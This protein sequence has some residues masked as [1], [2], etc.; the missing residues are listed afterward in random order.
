MFSRTPFILFALI[1]SLTTLTKGDEVVGLTSGDFRVDESGAATYNI[2]INTPAGRAGVTPQISLSYSS[3]SLAEGPVGVGWGVSGLSSISRCPQVPIHDDNI[4]E[5]QFDSEDKY[6]LDGQRLI[7]KSGTYG[8]NGSTYRTEVDN[9]SLITAKGSATSNGPMYFEISNKAGETHYYGDSSSVS[10][11]FSNHSD[12]FVE[13]GGYT[14]GSLARSW[15]LKV[16]KDV[17]D[18]Y[19]LFNYD[20]DT[21]E[22]IFY[23]DNIQY[24]GNLNTGAAPYAKM[25]FVYQDYDKGFKGYMAGAHINHNQI[26]ERIDTTIDGGSYRSYFLEY[27][28]SSFIE[29]RTLLT[30]VQECNNDVSKTTCFPETQFD[31]QR[32]A[33]SSSGKV[34]RCE[35]EPGYEHLCFWEPSTTNYQPFPTIDTSLA[36]DTDNRQTSQVFDINGDG[37]HD[38][39]YVKSGYWRAKLGPNFSTAYTLSSRGQ[40][41]KEYALSID[42]NGDGVRDL[43]VADSKSSYWYAISYQPDEITQEICPPGEPCEEITITTSVSVKNLGV[44]ATGLEGEAQVMDVNGDGLEDIVFRT[45][46]YIKAH[47]NNGNGGFTAN[48]L[49]YSFPTT[50]TSIEM[51][52]EMVSQ[53]ADMKSA[54]GIDINGDGRSDLILKVTTTTGGCYYR[55]RLFPYITHRSECIYDIRGTWSSSTSSNYKLFQSSG[56]TDSPT[57]TEVQNLGSASG[58]DTLRIAD[59]NGD[60]LSDLLYV[61]SDR[62]YYRLSDGTQLLSAHDA[63]LA[64]SSTK[65][66]LDQFVDLNGDGRTDVLHATNTSNWSVNFSR[67]TTDAEWV[68]FQPRGIRS[69]NTNATV[70]FG[71]TNGDGKLNMLTATSS[72]WKEYSNRAGTKENVI[73]TIT[74]GNGVETNITY[75][76]MTDTSVYVIQASDDDINSDTFSPVSGMQLVSRVTTDINNNNEVAVSYQYGG[77]LIHKNG[78]GSL[79]FEML[80]TTDEQSGVITETHYNQDHEDTGN[81]FAMARMPEYT[82]QRL[83]GALLSSASSSLSTR[84]TNQGSVLPYISQ[85]AEKSYVYGSDY[86]STEVSTTVSINAYDGWG[87]LTTSN[88]T[89]TDTVTGDNIETITTNN[90][91]NSTEQRLG[92]LKSTTVK[93]K[94]TGDT[95]YTTRDTVFTYNSDNLLATSVVS[96][97]TAAT[98]LTT[99][100]SY[101]T[102]GNKTS[103][104]VTGYSTATGTNQTRTT[105]NN[106]QNGGRFLNYKQNTLG[107]RVTYKYNGVSAASASGVTNSLTETDP[108]NLSTTSNFD[109]MGQITDIDHPDSRMT[110]IITSLCV[111]CVTNSYYKTVKI[112]TGSPDM[113]VY[114]DRWGREVATQVEGFNGN[115]IQTKTTYDNEGRQLRTYEPGSSTYYAQFT[116][117]DLGRVT[118]ITKPNGYSVTQSV[119]GLESWT[120]NELGQLSKTFSNGFGETEHTEDALNNLVTFTYDT[121]GN[122]L[123]SKTT[124][125]GKNSSVT[126][127]YDD[128]GRKTKTIDPVKGTWIYTYNAFGELYTQKTARN[129]TFF[130]TYDL[131]GRKVRSYQSSEGTLCWNYGSTGQAGIK[132]AGKLTSTAKYKGVS[133]SC[134][135]TSTPTIKKSFTYD[136]LGRPDDV[137]TTI[138]STS[139][140]QSQT[141]DSYSRPLVTTYPTGTSSFAVKNVYNNFNYLKEIRNNA[142]NALYKRIDSMT[143]RGKVNQVTLGNGVT[144]NNSFRSDTGWL[145]SIDVSKG[146]TLNTISVTYDG[147]GNVKTRESDYAASG[148]SSSHYTESYNYDNLNRL[149]SRTISIASGAASLPT[150]FKATQNFTLDDWGNFTFKTDA[151]YYKYDNTKVHKLLGVY[152]NANFTGT[153]YNFGYDNNGN[154]TSDGNR[155]FTYGSFDKPTYMSKSGVSSTMK[156]GASRELYFKQDSYTE[157]SS[158]VTYKTTYLGNYEKKDRTGGKGNLTEHKYYVGDIIVTQRSDAST[159]TYYLHKDH[160]G[161]VVATTNKYGAVISQAI[162]DPFGQ[163]TAVYLDSLLGNFTYTEPTD[164]GYTGHKHIAEMDIIHMGGRIYDPTLGRFMQADPI[165]QAPLDSQSYNRFA[166]VRNNPMSMTDPSGFSWLSKT[167]RKIKKWVRPIIAAVAAYYTFGAASAWAAN[168]GFTTTTTFAAGGAYTVSVSTLS[169][170]GY[171]LAGAASGFVGGAIMTGSLRGAVNGAITGAVGGSIA[172][173]AGTASRVARGLAGGMNGAM[174]TG[175]LKGF[176]RGFIAGQLDVDLGLRVY[177]SNQFANFAINR[178]SDYGRGYIIGGS[179]VAKKNLRAGL[180]ND[181]VGHAVGI[182]ASYYSNGSFKGPN[183]KN[184]MYYY[185]KGGID[186]ITI[187]NVITGP[188]NLYDGSLIG[189]YDLLDKHERKHFY[190]QRGLGAYYLPLQGLAAGLF[191]LTNRSTTPYFDCKGLITTTYSDLGIS[192]C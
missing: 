12:A 75:S 178:V 59:L 97:N 38:L 176:A 76:P 66:Y 129:H 48:R 93:K 13:P 10:G 17:K 92:R 136:S 99:S 23:I 31:W 73:N 52:E 149:S 36:T 146:G 107:E 14:T 19:I 186:A 51:G 172:S 71:D 105:T 125:N 33:L 187:G 135:T 188:T 4:R 173:Y 150:A 47:I 144:S 2:P 21:S 123:E 9:F 162:Y 29:E 54:S 7:L 157:G 90:F 155:S 39:I 98:K 166:Y 126:A 46:K 163:R 32:P 1:F 70:R 145:S 131:L 30:S 164:R 56:A 161:S 113:E 11:Y 104:S 189:D 22:G 112:V 64:T 3:N 44:I 111:S 67:P 130:F 138:G 148:L 139:Y 179:G 122:L 55:G 154:I 83:N 43:L 190:E 61:Q 158:S 86:V 124:A 72:T 153:L 68:Y 175:T 151:G 41:K 117:D 35:S 28:K 102:Y 45:S 24:T 60:G 103:V 185:D 108:N 27:E 58:K 16:I 174:Q 53:T 74:N 143:S 50:P 177:N 79:G 147:A 40:N 181:G 127:E 115:W 183:F 116:Y 121:F 134:T 140:T 81:A 118:Q 132:A 42:Y 109:D 69:F 34:W 165:V 78:R 49:L 167:W 191:Q 20:K 82:E 100:Y 57:L 110:N 156:Y 171:A 133:K 62:W 63:N 80:R 65:K 106:Y 119:Y 77:M 180:F 192:G 8:G 114:Y 184:G 169:V 141:Y 168:L 142:N 89:V 159:D 84:T 94:R 87:N 182:T 152:T 88:V 5:V 95:G 25:D 96:P 137:I 170:G 37:F 120:T 91:G 160:Q 15:A 85:S 128:W 18:N 101:D 26:L 6:C